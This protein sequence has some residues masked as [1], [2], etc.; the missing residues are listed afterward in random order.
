MARKLFTL[1]ALALAFACSCSRHEPKPVATAAPVRVAAPEPP[2]PVVKPDP[3]I[4]ADTLP[5]RQAVEG[6]GITITETAD[7]RVILK[8][9]AIWN[10]AMNTTY[11]TCDYYRNAVPVLRR[12]IA[13]DGA[14]LLDSVCAKSKPEKAKK[15]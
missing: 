4:S 13:K 10:E 5:P 12:Q 7:G 1:G 9:T 15:K 2:A 3:P 8:T 6:D 11:D 14:K